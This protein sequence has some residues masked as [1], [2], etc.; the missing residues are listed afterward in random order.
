MTVL[1]VLVA[2][3]PLSTLKAG[4]SLI[5]VVE[6]NDGGL[7]DP[8]SLRMREGELETGAA[9]CL[10]DIRPSSRYSNLNRLEGQGSSRSVD[11]AASTSITQELRTPTLD[12]GNPHHSIPLHF[13]ELRVSWNDDSNNIQVAAVLSGPMEKIQNMWL[14]CQRWQ[15]NYWMQPKSDRKIETDLPYPLVCFS[16]G[17]TDAYLNFEHGSL[18]GPA[19]AYGSNARPVIIIAIDPL[20]YEQY[21]GR[22]PG[23]LFFRMPQS[24]RGIGYS[25]YTFKKFATGG[26]CGDHSLAFPFYTEVDDLIYQVKCIEV[27][28]VTGEKTF[29]DHGAQTPTLLHA[30]LSLQ[31]LPDVGR[32]GLLGF[33]RNR[34]PVLNTTR[35]YMVNTLS[36][37][38]LRMLNVDLTKDIDYVPEL[39]KFEDIA[40]NHV[41]LNKSQVPTFKSYLFTYLA[42][43]R[44]SGGAA[45]GRDKWSKT[46]DSRAFLEDTVQM[47]SLRCC[48]QEVVGDLLAWVQKTAFEDDRKAAA[49]NHAA[50]EQS[51]LDT[52]FAAQDDE[53]DDSEDASGS[54]A[55]LLLDF[56]GFKN[57]CVPE[58][59][60]HQDAALRWL[61]RAEKN[62]RLKGGILA[63]EMGLGKTVTLFALITSNTPRRPCR[64]AAAFGPR[65]PARRLPTLIVVPLS[66]MAQWQYELQRHTRNLAVTTYYGPDRHIASKASMAATE[67]VI[68]TYD[69][70]VADEAMSD[71]EESDA[72][73]HTIQWHRVVCDEAAVVKNIRT[74]RATM[75]GRLRRKFCWLVTGSPIQNQVQEL[76]NLLKVVGYPDSL[77]NNNWRSYC[78]HVLLRRTLQSVITSVQNRG[79]L[80]MPTLTISQ[81]LLSFAT[82]REREVYMRLEE[83]VG[84]GNAFQNHAKLLCTLMRLRQACNHTALATRE[85]DDFEPDD[86]TELHHG[87]SNAKQ[88]AD[89]SDSGELQARRDLEIFG[90]GTKITALLKELRTMQQ[91]D[92]GASLKPHKCLVFSFFTSFLDLVSTALGDRGIAH[93]RLHGSMPAMAR[94]NEV[95][96]FQQDSA[97]NVFLISTKAGGLGLNLTEADRVIMMEPNWNPTDE[98]QVRTCYTTQVFIVTSLYVIISENRPFLRPFDEAIGSAKCDQSLSHGLSSKTL[99]NS[100]S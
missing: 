44:K 3:A 7:A 87:L 68:T 78:R 24:K 51:A 90:L 80:T 61:V 20:E 67:V 43:I 4:Q 8:V 55:R 34:G 100:A 21:H 74:G 38:K 31:R 28:E 72:F 9:Q 11:S 82:Q 64:S 41:L 98:E 71:G 10:D 58:L 84:S 30:L 60:P 69:T 57:D 75:V 29:I 99:S 6:N 33:V 50:M 40:F 36:I 1:N 45:A 63:D 13:A 35:D 53:V 46:T 25:R 49:R 88:I 37:Y 79:K 17:R 95:A 93:A 18:M 22:W 12:A 19:T 62:A 77:V 32:Y 26:F 97:C 65:A 16:R 2:A 89:S 59:Y 42:S 5:P 70:L 91:L 85:A 96:K 47:E 27:S 86:V 39:V 23:H 73:V 54:L 48:D 66:L 81:T 52:H 14:L 76:K 94:N 83:E 56:E 15:G 92:G